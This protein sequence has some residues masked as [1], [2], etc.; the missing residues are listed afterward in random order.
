MENYE[1]RVHSYI[2]GIIKHIGGNPIIVGGQKDHIHILTLLPRHVSL[3]E[4]LKLIKGKSAFWY[5]HELEGVRPKLIWQE[6]YDAITVSPDN[7][8]KVKNYILHQA[9][10][11]SNMPFTEE[12]DMMAKLL[13][14]SEDNS[15]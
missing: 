5:N 1:P 11:Q 7:L 10:H 14:E 2:A 15:D 8:E 9:M 6:G 4:V 3:S 13:V 12:R